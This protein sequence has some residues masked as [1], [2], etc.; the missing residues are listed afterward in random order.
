MS[1]ELHVLREKRLNWVK[2]NRENGF[3]EGINRLLTELYPDNAHFIYELL[4]NAEDAQATEITFCLSSE[5][6]TVEHNAARLFTEQD[7]QSITSIGDSTK[8][9]DINKIGKFGVG[10][11]AVFSYTD[12]PTIY[13]GNYAFKI[14]DLIVPEL[15][16]PLDKQTD[17]TVFEFPFNNPKKPKEQAFEE[18]ANG[19]RDLSETTLLFLTHIK[20]I[21]WH[22]ENEPPSYTRLHAHEEHCF[23]IETCLAGEEISTAHYLRFMSQIPDKPAHIQVGLAYSLH[24]EKD[25]H[26]F[27]K[28]TNG[29]VS[30]FFP[31]E[32]ETSNF[33]FHIHAPF[34]A[35]VARDSIKDI[36]ENV[37]LIT[38]IAELAVNSLHSIKTMGLLNRA[39]LD[40]LPNSQ[41]N[42]PD[43]YKP[44]REKIWAELRSQP[45][46]PT[47]SKSF[48]AGEQLYHATDDKDD[49]LKKLL[50]GGDLAYLEN[51]VDEKLEWC[52]DVPEALR[53]KIGIKAINAKQ[54][55]DKLINPPFTLSHWLELKENAWMQQFYSYLQPHSLQLKRIP[56]VRLNDGAHVLASEAYFPSDDIVDDNDFPRVC[57]ATYESGSE[58]QQEEREQAHEFLKN[59]GLKEVTECDKIE[60]IIE[61]WANKKPSDEEYLTYLRQFIDFYER[62]GNIYDFNDERIFWGDSKDGETDWHS[63]KQ[64]FIDSP[65]CETGIRPWFENDPNFYLLSKKYTDFPSL[66]VDDL[67]NFAKHLGAK[68]SAEVTYEDIQNIL[69]RWKTN[70]PN[71]D[72]YL[73][74]F[75]Q[76]IAAP[77]YDSQFKDQAIF[78]GDSKEGETKLVKASEIFIDSPLRVT[79]ISA[80]YADKWNY[81]LLSKRYAEHASL[82]ISAL[83]DFVKKLGAKD[84]LPIVKTPASRQTDLNN[85]F[86]EIVIAET[87]DKIDKDWCIS[88]CEWYCGGDFEQ[89]LNNPSEAKAHAIW[90]TMCHP[91]TKAE[92][93]TAWRKRLQRPLDKAQTRDSKLVWI[94]RQTAWIPQIN[95]NMVVAIF[96]TPAKA[97]QA[98]LPESFKYNDSNGWLTAIEF[99]KEEREQAAVLRR[100]DEQ[101]NRT[102]QEKV[103]TAKDNGFDSPE[104]MAEAAAF[105]KLVKSQGKSL[106]ELHADLAKNS[107][108]ELPEE[109]VPNPERR[110]KGVLERSENAPSKESVMRE[111]SVQLDTEVVVAEAKAYLRPKYTNINHELVCQCCQQEMPFKVNDAY[112]FEAVKC[113]KEVDKHYIEN[114]LALC[115]VCAAMYKHARKTDDLEIKRQIINGNQDNFSSSSIEISVAL[116]DKQ[117]KLRFVGK[118]WFDLSIVL[119][120]LNQSVSILE[121]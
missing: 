39:F 16:A 108:I 76:F 81:Y 3:D 34:A 79:G 84:R 24:S 109:S 67:I 23:E 56:L 88:N 83:I 5:K 12:T 85:R 66:N 107:N 100:Q 53:A 77:R 116:A 31:A 101:A 57:A 68:V 41:D 48:A 4:Q 106:T 40:V 70:K 38:A 94:L 35:T 21:N 91:D 49:K 50:D 30:I 36:A 118:H 102:Y 13:S 45:L 32:K 115:P 111:R 19:L 92:V 20:A 104:E 52:L 17:T 11:K 64:L 113:I 62:N 75:P 105:A 87:K 86:H 46:I 73:K 6:L 69:K 95:D 29:L 8:R 90:T 27:D 18:I 60:L 114:R 58:E 15:I 10:F 65:L 63:A 7:I 25:G 37:A 61:K 110:R 98:L 71:D 42:I 14:Y 44:I 97:M 121:K 51:R 89:W 28:K 33:R 119:N 99:G 43:F 78:W 1:V 26:T 93:L 47:Y 72:E 112:Y 55:I 103:N 22:S 9:D 80:W 120:S 2:S 96:V 82:D 59:I 74:Y 54:F 117:L